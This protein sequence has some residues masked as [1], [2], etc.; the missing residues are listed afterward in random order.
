MPLGL[1]RLDKLTGQV[2]S[3]LHQEILTVCFV[4]GAFWPVL[5]GTQF[6]TKHATLSASWAIGCCLMS[7][8]TLL[9]AN[10]IEDIETM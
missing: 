7:T 8:F 10:K 2:Q 3:Y 5:Y 6:I 9:P 1:W 4:L